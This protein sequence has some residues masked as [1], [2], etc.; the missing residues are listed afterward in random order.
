MNFTNAG[1][2]SKCFIFL[3]FTQYFRMLYCYCYAPFCHTVEI[4]YFGSRISR[5]RKACVKD[6]FPNPGPSGGGR[7]RDFSRRAIAVG[8]TLG[9]WSILSK[10]TGHLTSTWLFSP[11]DCKV[12]SV[13]W[14]SSIGNGTTDPR[15][16]PPEFWAKI[17]VFSYKLII[18]DI[19][20]SNRKLTTYS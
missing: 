1:Y 15:P 18:S 16:K 14:S 5:S 20:H 12:N 7:T 6:L 2:Y 4:D 9:L 19:W 10:D 17:N 13:P 8:E 11:L 3:L